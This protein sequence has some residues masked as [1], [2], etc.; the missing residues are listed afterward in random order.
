MKVF[1]FDE[2]SLETILDYIQNNDTSEKT[3]ADISG[4]HL[5]DFRFSDKYVIK[6]LKSFEFAI[7]SQMKQPT[8]ETQSRFAGHLPKIYGLVDCP[9]LDKHYIVMENFACSPTCSQLEIKLGF[10]NFLPVHW[11]VKQQS[12]LQSASLTDSLTSGFRVCMIQRKNM[13][14]IHVDKRKIEKI[15]G[16][17]TAPKPN[18]LQLMLNLQPEEE[19]A[20][21]KE[22][23]LKAINFYEVRLRDLL[24]IMS[25]H[26]DDLGYMITA[27]SL[28]FIIDFKEE[29]FDLR[30][31]DF[32]CS[33]PASRM[34][35]WN[36][37]QA[38][39]IKSLLED[40]AA[41]KA[42]VVENRSYQ[43]SVTQISN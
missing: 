14:G 8:N 2:V 23:L 41:V 21:K 36:F 43:I 37:E 18:S 16:I 39:A 24:D 31:F 34:D 27:A 42:Q 32:G 12:K 38:E 7:M 30:F 35:L 22:F 4:A 17:K 29:S 25:N 5:Q 15:K 28:M 10:Y 6:G 20:N 19:A 40:L 26:I 13:A 33:F 11:E 3:K 1:G 9:L